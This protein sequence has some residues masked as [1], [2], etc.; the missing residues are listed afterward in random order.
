[1]R[2]LL[3]S[4][5]GPAIQG[6]GHARSRTLFR[7]P[8]TWLLLSLV[9]L[10]MNYLPADLIQPFPYNVS[11]RV[12]SGLKKAEHTVPFNREIAAKFTS[13]DRI[14]FF[15]LTQRRDTVHKL[16]LMERAAALLRQRFFHAYSVY[17]L[18][19]NWIAVLAA[20]LFWQDL[21]AKVIPDDILKGNVAACSQ[22]SIVFM[23]L[24]N[25]FS[26]P[27]RK[28]GLKGHYAVEAFCDGRWYFFDMDIKPDFSL[29]G[30]RK[31]LA[32]ILAA[33]EQY[34]LYENTRLDS[35]NVSRVFSE[36]SYGK[37]N[38]H[39]APKAAFFHRVTGLMSHWG[40]LLPLSLFAILWFKK[41][42]FHDFKG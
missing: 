8:A 11:N 39:P 7:Y 33:G 41:G 10:L 42:F 12:S 6:S 34:R 26:V 18:E 37:I 40:W 36:V 1:M 25:K 4:R 21:A 28:V 13:T 20:R 22:I 17:T 35:A 23:D 2:R 38:A 14:Y 27:V 29:I 16:Q 24:C 5:P 19:E 31:G 32:D 15:L 3:N 9:M 30:G